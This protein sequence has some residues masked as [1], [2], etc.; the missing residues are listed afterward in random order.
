MTSL[1]QTAASVRSRGAQG[2]AAAAAAATA[3][4][5]Y[6]NSL[7]QDEA[8]H[9]HA[10][11]PSRASSL[12]YGGGKLSKTQDYN[13]HSH[14]GHPLGMTGGVTRV[15]VRLLIIVTAI[16]FFVRTYKIG[17]PSSVV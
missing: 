10:F 14:T 9:G 6:S 4:D 15:E 13:R 12:P 3:Q 1:G 17:Q 16:A 11:A 2:G 5:D 7:G 8:R